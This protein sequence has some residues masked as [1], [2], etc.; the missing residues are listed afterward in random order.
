ME[1]QRFDCYVNREIPRFVG[2]IC[3]GESPVDSSISETLEPVNPITGF[4]DNCLTRLLMPGISV[5]ERDFILSSLSQIKGYNSPSQLTD[6][7]L[8]ELLPSR[9]AQDPV[10]LDRLRMFVDS[11]IED[12]KSKKT[13]P[14]DP[15][16][17]PLTDPLTDPPT[18]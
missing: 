4:R 1:N 3:V 7:D 10:E 11:V 9:N 14:T 15:P 2:S 18:E 16:T 8:M 6:D 5:K 13:S 12:G 17:D